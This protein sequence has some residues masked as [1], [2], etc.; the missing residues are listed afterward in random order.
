MD[1]NTISIGCSGVTGE[2]GSN[3]LSGGTSLEFS[4]GNVVIAG[5]LPGAGTVVSVPGTVL[6]V[7]EPG[8]LALLALAFAGIG[9]SR[10]RK[11][12]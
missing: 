11:P 12:N 1:T 8:T 10:R 2:M 5:G 6:S 4:G 9:L 7:P 3:G